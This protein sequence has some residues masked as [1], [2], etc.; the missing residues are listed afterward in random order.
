MKKSELREQIGSVAK[1]YDELRDK[2]TLTVKHLENARGQVTELR[3]LV[4]YLER[5]IDR[6]R[7]EELARAAVDEQNGELQQ[8]LIGIGE[9]DLR[10]AQAMGDHAF[11]ML[12]Y[13]AGAVAAITPDNKVLKLSERFAT[14]YRDYL[15]ERSR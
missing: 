10:E 7:D 13:M 12:M 1:M 6:Q 15:L 11:E 4:Q 8:E 5:E 3:K 14:M 9:R 2:Y